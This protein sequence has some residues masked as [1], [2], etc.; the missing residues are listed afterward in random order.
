MA[1]V[2][3]KDVRERV[4]AILA[5]IPEVKTVITDDNCA[6]SE[7][8]LPAVIVMTRGRSG[9]RTNQQRRIVTKTFD[10]GVY[11][12]EI[13]GDSIEE[14]RAAFDTAEEFMEVI[15]DFF[16]KY[17]ARLELN[18]APLAGIEGIDEMGGGDL[19]TRPWTEPSVIYSSFTLQLP[20]RMIRF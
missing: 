2:T 6:L 5:T 14:Q 4:E 17:A 19:E 10:I 18:K 12:T 15:P 1:N 8:D 11:V 7:D 9:N 16:A 3:V 20:V 13:C